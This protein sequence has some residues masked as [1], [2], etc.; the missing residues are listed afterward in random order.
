MCS[1]LLKRPVWEDVEDIESGVRPNYV[2]QSDTRYHRIWVLYQKLLRKQNEE[3]WMWAWQ[4]RTW[5]DICTLLLGTALLRMAGNRSGEL[6]LDP[7]ATAGLE[8][9]GE[10][11]Q[12]SRVV[13]GSEP[14][15]FLI[16]Y[17]KH[18]AVL[19]LVHANQAKQHAIVSALG[20]TGGTLFLV[21][22]PVGKTRT[23][24]RVVVTWP[25]HV[26][27]ST[28]RHDFGATQKS[29]EQGLARLDLFVNKR[30]PVAFLTGLVLADA[31][32]QGEPDFDAG[33]TT[34]LARLAADPRLWTRNL[35]VLILL[36]EDLFTT[37]LESDNG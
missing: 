6:R 32:L 26:L 11:V 17:R 19:E 37:L 30:Y 28:L 35:D 22:K 24:P 23:P 27:S 31:F 21:F 1:E 9:L 14:G 29:A 18:C 33:S 25:V 36:L 20:S 5:A 10:Q 2:L 4:G 16:S 34:H 8:V 12:G 7:L 13:S 3:D 15:P